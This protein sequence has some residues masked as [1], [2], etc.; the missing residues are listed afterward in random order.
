VKPEFKTGLFIDFAGGLSKTSVSLSVMALATKC[1][2]MDTVLEEMVA[3]PRVSGAA[4]LAHTKTFA[5]A[6]PRRR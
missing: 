1:A 4:E 3:S 2:P 5:L 6:N